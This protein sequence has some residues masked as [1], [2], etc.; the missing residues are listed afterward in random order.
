M[1]L[2]NSDADR[3][4]WLLAHIGL[5]EAEILSVTSCLMLWLMGN[6]SVWGPRVGIAN[7]ML[8]VWYALSIDQVG[9]LV[10][11]IAYTVIHVRN[12]VR[13]ERMV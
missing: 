8:W 5:V 1:K 6:K 7:Q 3:Y 4:I 9:L 12:C 11:V 10:G 13:W 2:V